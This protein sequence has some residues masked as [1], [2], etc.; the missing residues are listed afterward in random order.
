MERIEGGSTKEQAEKWERQLLKLGYIPL[1]EGM[2]VFRIPPHSDTSGKSCQSSNAVIQELIDVRRVAAWAKCG[3]C[4]FTFVYDVR[5]LHGEL[6]YL[7]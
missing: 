1:E 7:D 4:E 3:G 6:P 5:D 2:V